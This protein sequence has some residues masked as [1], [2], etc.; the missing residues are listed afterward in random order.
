MQFLSTRMMKAAPAAAVSTRQE[1][2]S[3]SG[4]QGG[5]EARTAAPAQTHRIPFPP[6]PPE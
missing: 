1:Q 3:H 6:L 2:L 4:Q 5:P